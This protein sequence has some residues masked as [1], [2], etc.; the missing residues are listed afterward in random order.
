MGWLC[1]FCI[2]SLCIYIYNQAPNNQ[3][4]IKLFSRLSSRASLF[5]GASRYK[6]DCLSSSAL[7]L[8]HKLS[9]LLTINLKELTRSPVANQNQTMMKGYKDKHFI[10][11]VKLYR[12]V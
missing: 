6:T 12:Q 11:D 7:L 5:L 2:Y 9:L 8:I 1:H 10:L 3:C 4:L